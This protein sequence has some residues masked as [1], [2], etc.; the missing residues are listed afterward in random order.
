MAGA[1]DGANLKD[2]VDRGKEALK[3]LKEAKRIGGDN[4]FDDTTGKRAGEAADKLEKELKWAEEALDKL[5]KAASE[6]A[7]NDLSR[8]GKNE[9]K[10]AERAKDLNEK[11]RQGNRSLDEGTR[12]RLSE[13]EQAMRQAQRALEEGDGEQGKKHQDTAQRALEMAQGRKDDEGDKPNERGDKSKSDQEDP[14]SKLVGGKAAIPGKSKGPEAFRKRVMNGLS[15]PI[16]PALK[17]A[18]KRYA[19]GLLK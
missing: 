5:R 7:K 3:S 15:G 16:D 1:L 2:A 18:V 12:Q 9:E 10:L 11:A 13:A 8:S 4:L 14:E 19:E 17:E 6:R